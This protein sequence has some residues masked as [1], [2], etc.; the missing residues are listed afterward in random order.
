MSLIRK[1][2]FL[3]LIP[4]ILTSFTH[5]WNLVEFPNFYADEGHY[6]RKALVV[7]NGIS[8]QDKPG[9]YDAYLGP[10]FGQILL[11]TL[12]KLF[13]YPNFA[14]AQTQT[15]IELAML[16]PRLIMGIFAIIDTFLVFKIAQQ[17]YKTRIALFASILF[18]VTPMTWI[19][20]MITLDAIALPFLLISILISLNIVTWNKNGNGKISRHIFLVL[21]SGTCLGLAVLTK[22]PLATMIPLGIFL[23]Y[24]N[25]K[26]LKGKLPF[27]ITF[28]WLIPIFLIPS[29]WPV[30]AI[31]VDDF[32]LWKNAVLG[33]ASRVRTQI[34]ETFFSIDLIL[35]I[36][37]LGG[38]I[39]SVL[40]REWIL[41]LWIVP[42]LVFVYI[43][44][45]FMYFHWITVFPGFCIAAAK[46]V[47]ELAQRL[48]HRLKTEK[49]NEFGITI[50]I[51][52]IITAIGFFNTFILI[53]QD[54]ESAAIKG[55]A[56]SF[57]YADRAD[58]LDDDKINEKITMITPTA[59]SWIYTYIHKL[60]YAFDTHRDIA[61][62][63]IETDKTLILQ[64]QSIEKIF[65]QIENK[66]SSFVIRLGNDTKICNLD[67]KWYNT[68]FKTRSPL[69]VTPFERYDSSNKIGFK[70]NSSNDTE[71][72]VV[73]DMKN[74][75]AKYINMTLLPNAQNRTGYISEINIFGKNRE[76]GNE[77]EQ[78]PIKII[79]FT[80][81]SL[82]FN[83]LDNFETIASY[84]K[85]LSEDMKKVSEHRID[86]TP[87]ND[88]T[89]LLA[90][91]NFH[92]GDVTLIS[93]Y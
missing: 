11:G 8:L 23:I 93:N 32:E 73:I 31:Y 44:G 22:V 34:I 61:S 49:F 47:I 40:K 5:L 21:L 26:H 80:D 89:K 83:S 59:Y 69:L 30:Y 36:L 55:I 66:F 81:H 65:G 85:L 29:L 84:Q 19:T 58:G 3:L 74:A 91:F 20:R 38:L 7:L 50:T 37:G 13:G 71:N 1:E 35:L 90:G 6:M 57:D 43:H 18:A 14:M 41:V 77:C 60:N 54:F 17:V 27:K 70:I 48:A 87:L 24:K 82:F 10:F 92:A 45:W 63:K 64:R 39:Y 86:N 52:M 15:S 67:V 62:K 16:F 88:F 25:S 51:C 12:L 2:I 76:Y 28:I 4:L 68:D 46:F 56:D 75:S 42:F 33:Q 72:P 78:I 9:I 53:N 79:N